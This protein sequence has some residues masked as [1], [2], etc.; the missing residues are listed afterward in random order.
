MVS[1]LHAGQSRVHAGRGARPDTM[2]GIY[3]RRVAG[4]WCTLAAAAV[5]MATMA[6]GAAAQGRAISNPDNPMKTGIGYHGV[7]PVAKLGI[8]AWHFIGATRFGVFANAKAT[9]PTWRSKS[10]YCPETLE[11]CSTEDV[12]DTG[13]SI[14]YL[15]DRTDW[16]L[17]NAGAMYALSPDFALR[18]GAGVARRRPVAEFVD[19]SHEVIANSTFLVPYPNDRWDVQYVGSILLRVSNSLALTFGYETEPRGLALGASY[20]LP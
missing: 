9:F 14:L 3:M 6:G 12:R 15:R 18:V 17:L 1:E 16:M 5:L 13:G 7:F 19:E 11:S 10:H 2:R 4:S 20:V 8:D